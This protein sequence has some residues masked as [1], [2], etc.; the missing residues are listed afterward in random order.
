MH[1]Q[2]TTMC[3]PCK[4]YTSPKDAFRIPMLQTNLKTHQKRNIISYS[5]LGWT[6]KVRG[7][8]NLSFSFLG[9]V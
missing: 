8:I 1:S 4:N 9:E 7:N 5:F 6:V 2:V 3:P